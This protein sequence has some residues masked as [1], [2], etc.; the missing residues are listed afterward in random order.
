MRAGCK[1]AATG[2]TIALC[3]TM[4]AFTP[5]NATP[6]SSSDER[7]SLENSQTIM[8]TVSAASAQ[9]V[10]DDSFDGRALPV[11]YRDGVYRASAQGKLGMV[12]VTVTIE[13]GVVISVCVGQN[14][15]ADAMCEKAQE[16]IV[17]Q[18]LA[19]QSAEDID[20]VTGATLTSE[21]IVEAAAKALACARVAN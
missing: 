16:S 20:L 9:A 13:K 1:V 18:I 8:G 11:M 14:S 21:A 3:C 5:L 15:E 17:P 12:P 7:T 4:V 6:D 10:V 2:V 19:K